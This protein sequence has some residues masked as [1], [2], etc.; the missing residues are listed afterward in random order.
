MYT[1]PLDQ[2]EIKVLLML[3]DL[4]ALALT[5]FAL[6]LGLVAALVYGYVLVVSVGKLGT[7]RWGVAVLTIYDTI[8]NLVSSQIGR[9]GGRY[10]PFIFAV[11]NTILIANVVSMIPYSFAI[12]AQLVA[13]I[14]FSLSLWLGN[15][16]LGLSIHQ[17]RFFGLFVPG[18]TPLP[19]SP[20]LALIESLS[21]TSR[22]VSLGLRLS[23]NVL[24]GHLL[25]FILGSL[26]VKL[27][28]SSTLGFVVGLVPISAVTVITVL[29]MGIAVIQAYVFSILLSGYT[30]DS[31]EL[32]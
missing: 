25:M 28:G 32:H 9:L 17:S 4:L 10:F 15:V 12:S 21:F 8:L 11:F 19:L 22:S 18:G 23:A 5:N 6:Y 26:V 14:S 2:F 24:S 31:L 7:S 16:I 30:R 20:I 27:M 1:S 13:I 29:E 3:N